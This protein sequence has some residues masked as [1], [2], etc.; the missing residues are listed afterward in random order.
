MEYLKINN[1]NENEIINNNNN[2]FLN[3]GNDKNGNNLE[4]FNLNFIYKY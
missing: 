1:N 4:Y 3:F 2:N